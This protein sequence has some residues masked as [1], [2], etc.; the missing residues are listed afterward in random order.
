ML[1]NCCELLARMLNKKY[2]VCDG[3]ED[4]VFAEDLSMYDKRCK[5]YF[6]KKYSYM[7]SVIYEDISSKLS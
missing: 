1:I 3:K 5:I 4:I 7:I 2:F 6:F